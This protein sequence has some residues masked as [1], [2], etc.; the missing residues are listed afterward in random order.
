M[1]HILVTTLGI[2]LLASAAGVTAGERTVTLSVKNMTCVSCPYIV[3][4]SLSR[5]DGVKAVDVSLEKQQAVVR[6]DDA[7]TN[8]AA[9]TA[10]TTKFGFPSSVIE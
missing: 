1:K 4:K 2:A 3:K 5:V 10:A 6:Y 9:L 8:T 7:R